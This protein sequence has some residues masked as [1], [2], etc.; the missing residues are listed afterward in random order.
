MQNGMLNMMRVL[1]LYRK[2]NQAAQATEA[3]Q[4]HAQMDTSGV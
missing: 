1:F 2:T 3:Q 4:K